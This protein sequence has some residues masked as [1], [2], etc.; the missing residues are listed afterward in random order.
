VIEKRIARLSAPIDYSHLDLY[1]QGDR[2]LLDEILTIFEE[3]AA[4]LRAALDPS[5]TDDDWRHAAHTLKGASRGV[6]AFLLGDAA[7]A[8]EALVGVEAQIR[9]ARLAL[10]PILHERI[11]AAVA[12]ARILRD[13]E[14]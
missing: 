11:E 2:A 3:Q 10:L 8:A 9:D 5:A 12:Y 14:R 7:E 6:G 4:L 13:G 1:V